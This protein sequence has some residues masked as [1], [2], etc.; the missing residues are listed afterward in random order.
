MNTCLKN[1]LKCK[2]CATVVDHAPRP[3][4]LF[5]M[6]FIKKNFGQ[7]LDHIPCDQRERGRGKVNDQDFSY[8]V[9]KQQVT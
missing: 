2:I 5:S 9:K 4:P 1:T 6:T 8:L 3:R 7:E